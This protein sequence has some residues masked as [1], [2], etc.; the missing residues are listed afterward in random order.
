MVVGP[1]KRIKV[2]LSFP[3]V[4]GVTSLIFDSVVLVSGEKDA[5]LEVDSACERTGVPS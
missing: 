4:W 1:N 3:F 5:F 2:R